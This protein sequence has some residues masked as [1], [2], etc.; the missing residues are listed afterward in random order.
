[1]GKT[2]DGAEHACYA[3]VLPLKNILTIKEIAAIE[4]LVL[5][6]SEIIRHCYQYLKLF[7]VYCMENNLSFPVVDESFIRTIIKLVAIR[8][9]TNP[10]TCILEDEMTRFYKKHYKPIQVQPKYSAIGMNDIIHDV[11][12]QIITNI[13]NH[14]QG[15]FYNYVRKLARVWFHKE[16]DKYSSKVSCLVKDLYNG[17]FNSDASLHNLIDKYSA[18]IQACNQQL[19]Q[20][21]QDSLT[22]LYRINREIEEKAKALR[23]DE[24][25]ESERKIPK[26]F[27][28]FPLKRS[29]IPDAIPIN[30]TISITSFGG[31]EFWDSLRER[32]WMEFN[33]N[34]EF[35]ITSVRT[36]GVS[37]SVIFQKG[38]RE[39]KQKKKPLKEYY[40]QDLTKTKLKKL[41]KLNV[42]GID[43]N[44][45]TLAHCTDG[46]HFLRYTQ[47]ERQVQTGFRK[48]RKIRLFEE[49]KTRLRFKEDLTLQENLKL[50]SE[51]SGNSTT[52]SELEQYILQ[53][54]LF[55][56][57][58]G[59]FYQEYFHRKFRFNTKINTKRS[60]DNFIKRFKETYGSPD[61]VVVAFGDWEQHQGISFGKATTLGIGMRNIFRKHK[62][63]VFLINERATSKTCCKCHEENE[64]KF[65]KR[66]DPRPWKN[67]KSQAVWGLSRCKNINC[68]AVHNRDDCASLNILSIAT[69][70]LEPDQNPLPSP[71]NFNH[72]D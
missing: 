60:E 37:L 69:H 46:E 56:E 19:K 50:L 10:G 39:R 57:R 58:F 4:R 24:T 72:S 17:T 25:N 52:F 33:H 47:N 67:G 38:K 49:W 5:I 55:A 53:K 1:M 45:G 70:Y 61:E 36:N 34:E 35:H 41:N 18:D 3:R 42:V 8:S 40:L 6:K 71:F 16:T 15:H 48:Y 11:V 12:T 7:F 43:P 28:L 31:E 13:E 26:P 51:H 20:N 64:Y 65:L 62:Y 14:I 27:A 59:L 44:K 2:S 66:P 22:L 23:A 54:N 63:Q 32:L 30:K 68:R 9:S 21:P 29:L